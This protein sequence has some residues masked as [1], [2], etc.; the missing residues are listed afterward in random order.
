ME[1]GHAQAVV[2]KWGCSLGVRLPADA[3]GSFGLRQGVM[4]PHAEDARSA[5]A[6]HEGDSDPR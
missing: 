4:S 2:G 3:A 6:K 1:C 5:V